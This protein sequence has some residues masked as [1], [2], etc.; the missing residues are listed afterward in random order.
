M[1]S[2][3]QKPVNLVLISFLYKIYLKYKAD[4]V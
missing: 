4:L 3:L 2:R 1:D